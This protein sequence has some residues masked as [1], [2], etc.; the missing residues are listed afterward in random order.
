VRFED[1]GDTDTPET[2]QYPPQ[3]RGGTKNLGAPRFLTV[4]PQADGSFLLSEPGVEPA[5]TSGGPQDQ[6][7]SGDGRTFVIEG[8]VPVSATLCV[9]GVR[10]ADTLTATLRYADFP[11][12]PRAIRSVAVKYFLG[13]ISA[14]D[15]ERAAQGQLRPADS[16]GVA[17]PFGTVPDEYV[18]PQGRRRTNLRFEGWVDL[19]RVNLSETEAS[20]SI[21]CT[22]NTRLF[23]DQLAPPRLTVSPTAPIDRAIANYLAAFP[24]FRGMTVEYRPRTDDGNKPVLGKVMMAT[25]HP[26]KN[27]GPTPNGAAEKLSVWDYLTDVCGMVGHLVRVE[28]TTVVVQRAR[29]L[30]QGSYLRPDDPFTGRT[31]SGQGEPAL[32]ITQ[33]MYAYGVN[34]RELEINRGFGKRQVS[35]VEVRSYS[36]RRKKTIVVRFPEKGQRVKNLRPGDGAELKFEVVRVAGIEDPKTMMVI[37]QNYYEAKNRNEVGV[38]VDTKHLA[39]FGGDNLDPDALDLREGDAIRIEIARRASDTEANTIMDIARL[40][41][42]DLLALGFDPDLCAAY[43]AALTRLALPTTFRLRQATF[44]WDETKGVALA[45]ECI[46]YVEVRVD[47]DLPPGDEPTPPG[48]NQDPNQLP[49]EKIDVEEVSG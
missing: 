44:D 22:D 28:G 48:Q 18:D 20:V 12:D 43:D 5:R 38:K 31:I 46:N 7:V 30:Y 32:E 36:T 11:F 25:A 14:D 33:R 17:L 23:I 47:R 13:C 29:T 10:Q 41:A 34:V 3:N 19:D 49:P 26:R 6:D 27:A 9:N 8:V 24:Q 40:P 2:P 21:E 42:E 16:R 45:F 35:N 1:Y 4:E 37:A 15:A 39:S